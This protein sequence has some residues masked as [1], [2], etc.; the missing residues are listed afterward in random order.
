MKPENF[1]Q[2]EVFF[3]I[4]WRL[5]CIIGELYLNLKL[6]HLHAVTVFNNTE[7]CSSQSCFTPKD[8][9]YISIQ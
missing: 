7:V 2:Y 3:T 4:V 8:R 5:E 9:L 1:I 6:L